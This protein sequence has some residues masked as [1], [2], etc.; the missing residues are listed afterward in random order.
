MDSRWNADEP[1]VRAP[2]A[3][4]ARLLLVS[5]HPALIEQ[6]ARLLTTESYE[7]D[8]ASDDW[9]ALRFGLTGVY[10]V[11]VVDRDLSAVDALELLMRLRVN[12]MIA[13]I[14]L[15]SALSGAA[16]LVAGLDA[17]AEDYLVAPFDGDELLARLRALRRWSAGTVRRLLVP[18][19][20]L[21]PEIRLVTL[22]DGV[23]VRLS[24]RESALLATLAAR[25]RKVFWRDELRRIVFGG[26]RAK[27]VDVYV[28]Y[29]R[30][31]LGDDV[32]ATV[33]GRGYRLGAGHDP[34]RPT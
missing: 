4:P 22:F 31:K 9:Q 12:G 7:V 20:A 27:T 19:G 14:L 25:P 16:D 2:D 8:V 10:D 30:R 1:V 32:V 18:G 5:D 28:H 15:L 34:P 29:L 11:V 6:L 13:P 3:G 23:R 17:G 33:R 24:A 26:A 21:D